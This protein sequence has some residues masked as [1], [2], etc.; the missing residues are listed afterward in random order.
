MRIAIIFIILFA[1][2]DYFGYNEIAEKR[3]KLILYRIIQLAVFIAQCITLYYIAGLG[4][5]LAFFILWWTWNADLCYYILSDWLKFYAQD[6]FRREV[7]GNTVYWANWT[8]YG[9]YLSFMRG[10]KASAP[11][12]GI[13]LLI[14]AFL[15][16]IISLIITGVF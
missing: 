8:P 3:S 9:L 13:G 6:V 11:I 2:F 14:Q 1:T 5:A 12:D 16:I 4:S 15:G 10:K 7:M